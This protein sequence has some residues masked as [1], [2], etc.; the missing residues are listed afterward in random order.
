[1]WFTSYSKFARIFF[2]AITVFTVTG[3]ATTY[4]HLAIPR[5]EPVAQR[6]KHIKPQVILV[7]GS[8]SSRGFAHAGVLKVLE[9]NH[10]PID[11]I[12]GT[13]A[14]SIVGSLYA[15]HPS[16]AWLTNLLL[17]TQRSEVIDFS[18]MNIR[19]GLVT[20]NKLQSFLI[21][22]LHARTFDELSIPFVAVATDLETGQAHVFGSG[23]I[24]PAVNASSAASPFFQPVKLYGKTYID[25][26]FVDPVAVDVAKQYHPKII[27]A[28]SLNYTLQKDIPNSSPSV[29]LKGFDMMLMQLNE[30]SAEH[31]Q[32]I[33]RPQ[34]SEI[35]MF[36]GSNRMDVIKSGEVAARQA[37]PLIKKLLAQHRIAL[38]KR[39][40]LN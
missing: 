23:P 33:I 36:D 39:S 4:S 9:E 10:I 11:M 12:V 20:G 22:H 24:A 8:G 2:L 3:C 7:L 35:D 28:V 30:Y 31:A 26:G 19:Q 21:N 34:P 25:G 16:S 27:I 15:D 38:R 18:L 17:T 6:L 5:S 37:L 29:F 13:S 14:G 1:M 32:V 40:A